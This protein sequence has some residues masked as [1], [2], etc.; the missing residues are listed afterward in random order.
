MPWLNGLTFVL[1]IALVSAMVVYLLNIKDRVLSILTGGIMVTFAPVMGTVFFMFTAP[2][3]GIALVFVTLAAW[4]F[5]S[6]KWWIKPIGCVLGILSLGIYQAYFP[7]CAALLV[8]SLLKQLFKGKS[9]RFV[10]VR[11]F[12]YLGLLVVTVIGYLLITR[13]FW[14][15]ELSAY[16]GA[17][18]MGILSI[19]EIPMIIKTIYSNY[20]RFHFGEFSGINSNITILAG[21]SVLCICGI[22]EIVV[23]A[24]SRFLQKECDSVLK[25]LMGLALMAIFPIAVFGIYLMASHAYIYSLMFYP[26]VLCFIMPVM[27]LD[28]WNQSQGGLI[29]K[30][31]KLEKIILSGANVIVTVMLT[32]SILGYCHYDNEYYLQ[33]ALCKEQ[34]DSI[35][36]TWITQIKSLDGYR[37]DMPV[38]FIGSYH[39]DT[40]YNAEN[41]FPNTYLAGWANYVL[42]D[43]YLKYME[44]YCGYCPV[45]LH[46]TSMLMTMPEVQEMP[47]YPTSGS[48]RIVDDIVVFKFSE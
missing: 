8:L 36:T 30:F 21:L 19:T 11:A 24:V 25:G 2:F 22:I 39:D 18:Q 15:E 13:V 29:R 14:G 37:A 38:A 45:V 1:C 40:Y 4:M 42:S 34:T 41:Y 23:Y 16:Q 20:R 27:L 26:L 28:Q 5:V 47:C 33:I 9:F 35:V 46:D 44:T 17:D 3:Y 48:I 12:Q 32:L 43:Q 10:L 6:E 31:P 7:F